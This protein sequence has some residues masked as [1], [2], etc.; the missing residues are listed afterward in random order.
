MHQGIGNVAN[1]DFFCYETFDNTLSNS[2]TLSK[3]CNSNLLS[4]QSLFSGQYLKR[5]THLWT[6]FD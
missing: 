2:A 6:N 3:K 4:L 5:I 1:V